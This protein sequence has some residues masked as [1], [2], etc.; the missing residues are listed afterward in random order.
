MP[1]P[2]RGKRNEPKYVKYVAE[3][4]AKI[5]NVSIDELAEKTKENFK[6]LFRL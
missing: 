3:E 2:Y 6:R 1:E 5:R 4:I